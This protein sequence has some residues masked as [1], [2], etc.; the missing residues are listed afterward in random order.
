MARLLEEN[1]N[2]LH[3][4]NVSDVLF[5]RSY[6]PSRD[7]RA[8]L[9][10]FRLTAA[11]GLLKWFVRGM[12]AVEGILATD[13]ERRA[14]PIATLEFALER[15]EE[16]VAVANHE[17]IEDIV[18][19]GEQPSDEEWSS[20]L[21]DYTALL[22]NDAGIESSME[23]CRERLQVYIA[24]LC[25]SRPADAREICIFPYPFHSVKNSPAFIDPRPFP[26]VYI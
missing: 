16:F 9:E 15:C 14:I 17:D 2:W 10:D 18:E 1:A 26:P 7:R 22:H 4:E 23:G 13:R 20:F 5:P 25:K 19:A 8:F 6:N 12:S 3:E 21:E 11:A 24:R